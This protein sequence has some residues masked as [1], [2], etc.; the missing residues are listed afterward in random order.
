MLFAVTRSQIEKAIERC[1]VVEAAVRGEIGP[2][3]LSFYQVLIEQHREL[4]EQHPEWKK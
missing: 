1:A 2:E 3:R 4:H